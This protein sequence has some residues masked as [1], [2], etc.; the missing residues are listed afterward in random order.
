VKGYTVEQA[1]K[2]HVSDREVR[3]GRDTL[4]LGIPP[5]DLPLQHHPLRIYLFLLTG[6]QPRE[7]M[8]YIYTAEISAAAVS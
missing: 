6:F 4:P 7:F 8:T 2:I 5:V 1:P 3:A